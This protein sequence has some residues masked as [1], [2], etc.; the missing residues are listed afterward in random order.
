M[1]VRFV[2][3]IVI[4]THDMDIVTEHATKCA[5]MN[6]G[7]VVLVGTPKE[8]FSNEEEIKKAGLE[9]P[10]TAFLQ[11]ELKK[12]GVIIDSDLTVKDFTEK[13]LAVKGV[14]I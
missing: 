1:H 5:V 13:L 7:K 6:D 8:V 3:T 10:L 14:E 12:T 11:N 9:L 4:I 2:K